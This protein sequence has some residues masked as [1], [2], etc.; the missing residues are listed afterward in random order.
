[1]K[2]YSEVIRDVRKRIV[3]RLATDDGELQLLGAMIEAF[4]GGDHVEIGVLFG[5][6]MMFAAGVLKEMG[7]NPVV[8]GIDPLNGYYIDNKDFGNEVDPITQLPITPRVCMDNLNN[9]DY[10]NFMLCVTKSDPFPVDGEFDT[11]LIDGDH[12][13]DAPFRDFENLNKFVKKAIMF[14]NFDSRHGD[15]VLAVEKALKMGWHV[16]SVSTSG[17]VIVRD[18]ENN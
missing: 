5:G 9:Y 4:G 13:G 15:I 7:K 14:D 11:A 1:M 6:T 12:W 18:D 2:D 10:D 17:V 8:V 3:G 16:W